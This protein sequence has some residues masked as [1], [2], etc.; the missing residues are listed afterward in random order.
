MSDEKDQDEDPGLIALRNEIKQWE[1]RKNKSAAALARVERLKLHL[2]DAEVGFTSPEAVK[3]LDKL[4]D[5]EIRRLA[6]FAL[7]FY[8]NCWTDR[9]RDI[10]EGCR[11][12]L[13]RKGENEEMYS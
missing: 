12:V 8:D 11:A 9:D 3:A 7:R 4:N 2:A 6:S 13:G 10:T 5:L 1:S